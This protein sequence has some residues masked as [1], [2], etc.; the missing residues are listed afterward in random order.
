MHEGGVAAA[1]AN[2]LVK[3]LAQD[4]EGVEGDVVAP[5]DRAQCGHPHALRRAPS[6]DA[7]APR[8]LVARLGEALPGQV[9]AQAPVDLVDLVHHALAVVLEVALVRQDDVVLGGRRAA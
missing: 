6:G 5:V 4:V 2:V 3:A 9:P 1:P 7:E 8:V